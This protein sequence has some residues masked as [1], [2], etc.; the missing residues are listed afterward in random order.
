MSIALKSKK[1]KISQN[2]IARLSLY[3]RELNLCELEHKRFISSSELARATNLTDSQVRK[4][5]SLFGNFGVSGSGYAVDKLRAEVKTILGK[6][7]PIDVILVGV[8]NLGSAL[9]SY[10]DF[11]REGIRIRTAFDVDERKVGRVVSNVQ[12]RTI[13]DMENYI[14]K[15]KMKIAILAIPSHSAQQVTDT[16]VK[17]GIKCILNF[18]PKVLKTANGTL[19]RNVDLSREFD[20]FT[21]FI[22]QNN[23]A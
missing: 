11:Q 2:S 18:A 9:L 7:K 21:Y 23:N 12:I 22:R 13:A 10:L 4:D 16:L 20:F 5:L 15:E 17:A 1:N 8:G 19:I 14:K 6:D 3:L